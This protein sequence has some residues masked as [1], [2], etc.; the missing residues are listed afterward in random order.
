MKQNENEVDYSTILAE[1]KKKMNKSYASHADMPDNLGLLKPQQ[2]AKG[3]I[4]IK[5]EL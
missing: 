2:K 5:Y 3:N 1:K 4:I